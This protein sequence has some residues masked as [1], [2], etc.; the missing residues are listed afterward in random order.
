MS[1]KVH[2]W[3]IN[4]DYSIRCNHKIENRKSKITS[5]F[6]PVIIQDGI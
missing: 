4:N 2:I 5:F 1:A 6:L 3:I